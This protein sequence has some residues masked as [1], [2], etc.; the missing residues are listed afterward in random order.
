MHPDLKQA[1]RRQRDLGVLRGRIGGTAV[2]GI[3]VVAYWL[4]RLSGLW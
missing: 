1:G 4:G 3:G 2:L